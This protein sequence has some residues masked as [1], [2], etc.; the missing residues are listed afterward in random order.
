MKGFT[1]IE[2]LLV[3]AVT[4]ILIAGSVVSLSGLRISASLSAGADT[5]KLALEKS[6]LSVLV[7]ENGGGYKLKF[8]EKNMVLF[9]GAS[10]DPADSSNTI[11]NLPLGT[12]ITSINL[13]AGG[14]VVSFSHLNGTTTPGTIVLS[15]VN[16]LTHTRTIYIDG[17]GRISHQDTSSV[18]GGSGGAGGSGGQGQAVDGGH[19]DF[20][21][22]WSIQNTSE[23]KFNFLTTPSA[24]KVFIM[25]PH[26]NGNHTVFNYVGYFSEG[27]VAQ[28]IT[29]YSS[30]LDPNNTVMSI[31]REPAANGP[32]LEISIDDR[33]IATYYSD[34]TV[35][36]GS[37]GGIMITQ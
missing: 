10:Y 34:G 31:I 21:L 9:K 27:G 15:A 28:K 7:K 19:Q 36:A 16:D 3:I 14:D 18:G 32:T 17:T 6:R 37:G 8:N 11:I 20:N 26:F 23:L 13:N 35:S 24:E 2:V 4:G 12:E 29:M 33:I 1:L 25:Q 30:Q 5:I 22:G